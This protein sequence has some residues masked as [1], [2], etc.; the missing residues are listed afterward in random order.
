MPLLNITTNQDLS[1]QEQKQ[2]VQKMSSAVA[3]LLG[4][5]ENYVMVIL[6]SNPAMSFAGTDAPLAYLELK[7]LGLPE[8][9]TADFSSV[10][11]SLVN[12]QLG[13]PQDRTYIEFSN[14]PRHFWGWNNST[15]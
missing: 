2:V 6:Q 14:P 15:F 5:P 12:E 1:D 4:K 11:C 8:E 13:I 10:L 3:D 9:K 7:S